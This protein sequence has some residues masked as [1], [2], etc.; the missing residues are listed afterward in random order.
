MFCWQSA[1]AL[2]L[3]V[4]VRTRASSAVWHAGVCPLTACLA[5]VHVACL[6][7]PP[8]PRGRPSVTSYAYGL[9]GGGGTVPPPPIHTAMAIIINPLYEQTSVYISTNKRTHTGIQTTRLKHKQP[10]THTHTH[11]HIHTHTHTHIH[12]H[13]HKHI[14]T[15]TQHH[16]QT[17]TYKNKYARQRIVIKILWVCSDFNDRSCTQ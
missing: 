15:Q 8:T 6:V 11:T 9:L 17:H 2:T 14:Q 5:M 10:Y 4:S 7:W 1:L 16:K 3:S 13:K 12:T